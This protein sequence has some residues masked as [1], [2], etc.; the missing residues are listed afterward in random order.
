M[1]RDWKA[2]LADYFD[3]HRILEKCL[4]ETR[5][6]FDQF[7]EFIAEPAFELLTR[8]F[9]EYGI[10]TKFWKTKGRRV[11][12]KIDF[13]HSGVDHF[14]YIIELPK[15]ALEMQP[16]L[17]V[18]GR[19]SRRSRLVDRTLPFLPE[20]STGELLR[21]DKETLIR[22]IIRHYR[23]FNFEGLSSSES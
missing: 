12:F 5:D 16:R 15:N 10:K 2:E 18:R 1:E 22:D 20:A 14:Y 4:V 11:T 13:A 7:C 6:N 19:K 3:E 21:L 8:E 17:R 23:D 9:Q